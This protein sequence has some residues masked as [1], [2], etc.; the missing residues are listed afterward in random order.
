MATTNLSCYNDNFA[1]TLQQADTF[2]SFE[3]ARSKLV[4]EEGSKAKRLADAP[5]A[6]HSI[7]SLSQNDAAAPE[8]SQNNSTDRG[9]DNSRGRGRGN[10][11]RG[12]GNRGRGP[13]CTL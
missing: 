10:R 7:G 9:N 12:R 11:G 8:Q 6:L 13:R 3:T 5:T 2:P 1:T 4:L